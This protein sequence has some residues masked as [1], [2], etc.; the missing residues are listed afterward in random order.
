V[1]GRALRTGLDSAMGT[2]VQRGTSCAPQER[3][4]SVIGSGALLNE[5][6][7]DRRYTFDGEAA[8]GLPAT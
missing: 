6:N 3:G 7:R 8:R 2:L 5:S 1:I 4:R